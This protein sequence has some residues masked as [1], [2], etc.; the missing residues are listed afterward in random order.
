[1]THVI[2]EK[3]DGPFAID[4]QFLLRDIILEVD[5]FG[6]HKLELTQVDVETV[7]LSLI[8]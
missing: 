4:V 3:S 8:R 1:M 5:C 6:R 2:V 7:Q